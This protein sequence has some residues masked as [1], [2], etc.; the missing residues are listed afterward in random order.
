VGHPPRTAE[1]GAAGRRQ[2][3]DPVDDD[4]RD[5]HEL[6]EQQGEGDE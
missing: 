1:P 3:T 5:Q 4:A 6:D 2:D